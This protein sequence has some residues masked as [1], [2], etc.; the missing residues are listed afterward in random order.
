MGSQGIVRLAQLSLASV[1]SP[2]SVRSPS[3]MRSPGSVRSP[4]STCSCVNSITATIGQRVLT[5]DNERYFIF[6]YSRDSY[7]IYF[8]RVNA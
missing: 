6:S 8:L 2:S 5:R 7:A 1:H 3:S 4:S